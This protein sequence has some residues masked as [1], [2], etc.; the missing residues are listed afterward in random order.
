M[1]PLAIEDAI[2]SHQRPKIE[3][4]GDSWFVVV[5]ASSRNGNA[6]DLHEL[7]IFIGRNFVVT[8]R[9]LPVYPLD[10]MERRWH[11]G[12]NGL[13]RDSGALL[14]TILDTVVDGYLPIVEAFEEQVE[15]LEAALLSAGTKTNAILMEIFQMRK[16]LS[17][18]RG[19]VLPIHDILVPIIRGDLH[20]FA[21]EDSPYYRDIND[22]V[23]RVVEQLDR[24]RE[25]I[26]NARDIHIALATNRQNEVT[27]QLTIV[28][29]IFLPLTFVTGFYGQNFGFL[30]NHV[31]S[32][33]S[34]WWLGVG[35]EVVAIAALLGYFRFKHWF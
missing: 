7:A 25:L 19:A 21:D 3:A 32:A 20:L 13:P 17:R 34:F 35:S 22:H 28:A 26:N 10:E 15:A 11:Q 31:T 2:H 27:K 23:S 16:N 30:V 33:E 8:V 6:L 9:A 1:H 12:S 5:H 24:A 4:Y 14:Y 29:T 18:F